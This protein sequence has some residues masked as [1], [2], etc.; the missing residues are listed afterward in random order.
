MNT[1]FLETFI[2]LARL[3]NFS[4]TAEKL[5]STQPAVSSRINALEDS[6]RVELYIR[7]SRPLELTPEGKKILEYAE[8]IYNLEQHMRKACVSNSDSSSLRIGVIEIVTVTWLT[9]FIEALNDR[10]EDM[11]IEITTGLHS[12]L[13]SQLLNEDLDLILS[14]GPVA[15]PQIINVPLCGYRL[16]WIAN[17]NY[18]PIDREMDILEI[19]KLPIILTK[20]NSSIYPLVRAALMSFDIDY[21][22]SNNQKVRFDCVYSLA[23]AVHLVK[24]GVGVMPLMPITI[25]DEIRGNSLKILEVRERMPDVNLSAAYKAD[26]ATRLLQEV[27]SIA[28]EQA[29]IYCLAA[30]EQYASH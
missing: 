20:S 29:G 25:L 27:S 5:H 16:N 19:A 22:F 21:V 11:V 7:G 9:S 15:D 18:F 12:D 13:V 14:L 26:S 4:K 1:K 30:G 3:G 10:Y 8:K 24:A 28:K 23:T 2:W 6:L 17:P